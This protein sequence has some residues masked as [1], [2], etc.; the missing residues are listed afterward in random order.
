MT[1]TIF[2]CLNGL[3]PCPF[4]HIWDQEPVRVGNFS[5]GTIPSFQVVC[6]CGARG[7]N[8]S[9]PGAAA[10]QWNEMAR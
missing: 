5:F 1:R 3:L 6:N 7:P 2:I 4:P 8:A 9:T 10:E